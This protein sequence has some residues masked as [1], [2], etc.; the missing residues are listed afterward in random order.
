MYK[1]GI[2]LAVV[3]LVIAVGL[4]LLSPI[5]PPCAALFLGLGAGFLAGVFDKP[6]DN[7]ESAKIGAIAG[8]IGGVGALLG[9]FAGAGLNAW[10][11]GPE[12][13]AQIMEQLGVDAGGQAGF[14]SGYW[15]GIVGSAVCVGLLDVALMAGFGAVGGLLWWQI[16]GKKTNVAV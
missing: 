12:K 9:Q 4:T 2:I 13:A 7:N 1:S 6:Q 3:A 8:G 15:I 5:C 14:G 10:L 16:T 11:V